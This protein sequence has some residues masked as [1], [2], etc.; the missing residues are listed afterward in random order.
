MG[1][2]I[3]KEK[4]GSKIWDAANQLRDKL[5][6]HEYKDYVLGLVFYKFLCEKQTN[7]LIKNWITS[8]RLKYLDSKYLD[9]ESN[10]NAIVSDDAYKS[11][12]E[13]LVDAKKR[14]HWRKWLF[15]RLFK[16]VFILTWKQKWI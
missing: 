10:F 12:Y 14:L 1:N 8:D 13:N 2:K 15:Y 6:P 4:L 9:N 7:Y 3:T 5:E 16:L 11:D